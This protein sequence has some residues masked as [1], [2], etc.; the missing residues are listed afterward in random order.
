MGITSDRNDPRLTHGAD[1][2]PT[3]QAEVYLVLSDEERARG[4]VRPVRQSYI[5]PIC[6]VVTTMGLALAETYAAQPTFYGATYCVGCR[7]HLPVGEFLWDK[8]NE[9]VGS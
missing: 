8:T 4:F 9:K 5:H 6:G 1:T 3:E 2:G 7:R